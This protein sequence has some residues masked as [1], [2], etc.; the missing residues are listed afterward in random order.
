MAPPYADENVNEAA[1]EQGLEAAENEIRDL[2]ADTYEEA[3]KQSDDPETN[4]DDIDRTE[5][6]SSERNASPDA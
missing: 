6:E 4:L 1:T 3:A 2:V 5:A